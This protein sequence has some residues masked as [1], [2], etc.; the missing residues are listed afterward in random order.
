MTVFD[1][2]TEGFVTTIVAI[3]F[4]VPVA[5]TLAII[6]LIVWTVRRATPR[7]DPAVAELKVRYARG[8]IDSS[9][10]QARLDNL[11]RDR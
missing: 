2:F 1:P 7:D 5:I 11:N 4:I 6:G 3:S 9:E 8:E 10:F